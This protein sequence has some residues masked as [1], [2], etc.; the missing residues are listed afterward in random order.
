MFVKLNPN[1][2]IAEDPG[3]MFF[4]TRKYKDPNNIFEISAPAEPANIAFFPPI[5]SVKGPPRK[6]VSPY[7]ESN[8]C[9]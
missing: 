5:I 2:N 7:I 4:S 1:L 9:V 8:C 6:T 3:V